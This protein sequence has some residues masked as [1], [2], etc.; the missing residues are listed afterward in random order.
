M[1]EQE[2]PLSEETQKF[3]D[4]IEALHEQGRVF[5]KP[6]R[7]S[8]SGE[9]YEAVERLARSLGRDIRRVAEATGDEDA[10]VEWTLIYNMTIIIRVRLNGCYGVGGYNLSNKSCTYYGIVC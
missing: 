5:E 4:E 2:V 8:S 10:W 6:G 3:T 7:M 1:G 9:A